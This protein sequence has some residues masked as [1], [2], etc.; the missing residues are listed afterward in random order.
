MYQNDWPY[1]LVHIRV[2]NQISNFWCSKIKSSTHTVRATRSGIREISKIQKLESPETG[3]SR[4]W[5]I[6]K[7]ENPETLNQKYVT[8]K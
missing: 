7:L 4:N 1:N 2:R 8:A 5:K 3:K 6:Q